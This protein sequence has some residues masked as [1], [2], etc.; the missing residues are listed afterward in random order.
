MT[1]A[2]KRRTRENQRQR[3]SGTLNT[4]PASDERAVA[5]KPRSPAMPA[6]NMTSHAAFTGVWVCL[7]SLFHQREP[8][9]ALSRAKA[10]TTR[11]A[12]TPCAAP[13]TYF[14]RSQWFCASTVPRRR[15]TCTMMM[16]LQ[17]ASIPFLPRTLRN[18]WP[19]GNGR[20]VPSRA[21]TDEVAKDAAMSSSQPRDAVSKTLTRIASGAAFAAP[22]V[23]S[24]MCA[25]ESSNRMVKNQVVRR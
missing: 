14:R 19:I 6:R 21:S 16:K 10:N 4:H 1:D 13:V 18:S 11:E 5:E 17:R 15:R 23:S 8:G 3:K 12:S 20:S 2:L 9:S 7:L 25:A 22:A 24:E